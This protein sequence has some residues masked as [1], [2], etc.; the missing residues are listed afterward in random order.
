MQVITKSFFLG[1]GQVF[2]ISKVN[3]DTSL[4]P[5]KADVACADVELGAYAHIG[6]PD[7]LFIAL[8]ETLDSCV[9]A[10]RDIIGLDNIFSDP[11]TSTAPFSRSIKGDCLGW[12]IED[13]VSELTIVLTVEIK[14][15]D[16]QHCKNNDLD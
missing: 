11:I 3:W 14:Q 5:P 12:T 16:W 6:G 7:D 10:A 4:V 2:R 1:S 13:R 15:G 8:G 9:C